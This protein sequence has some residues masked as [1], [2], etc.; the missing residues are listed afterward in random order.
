VEV[1][2]MKYALL[3]Y[4]DEA[5]SDGLDEMR[6]QRWRCGRCSTSRCSRRRTVLALMPAALE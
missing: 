5:A 6:R 1:D 3:L 4:A 2:P